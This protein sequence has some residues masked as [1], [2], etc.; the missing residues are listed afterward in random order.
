MEQLAQEV[1]KQACVRIQDLADVAENLCQSGCNQASSLQLLTQEIHTRR[2]KL[3]EQIHQNRMLTEHMEHHKVQL[4]DQV[5]QNTV[6]ATEME[7]EKS[8]VHNLFGH[9]D[10][11]ITRLTSQVSSLQSANA[12]LEERLAA[13]SATPSAVYRKPE[14]PR[15]PSADMATQL[16]PLFEAA[17]SLSRRMDCFENTP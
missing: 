14:A 9:K 7:S 1:C 2:M 5:H 6:S 12:R 13:M 16:N 11:E 15:M 17:K 10:A 4:S 8:R 3:E